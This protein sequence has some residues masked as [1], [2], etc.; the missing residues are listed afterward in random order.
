MIKVYFLIRRDYLKKKDLDYK[1]YK[2]IF[3]RE[4]NSGK[5]IITQDTKEELII[6]DNE[7][8]KQCYSPKDKARSQ[9]PIYWF[10]SDQGNLISVYK[11]K[12]YWL[13]KD[14]DNGRY[15]YH[16]NIYT[17]EETSV[18]KNIEAHNLVRIVFGGLSYGI[19]EDMLQEQGI[20]AFGIK[21]SEE[22]KLNGHHIAD[23]SDNSPGN[24]ELVSTNA[25]KIIDKVPKKNKPEAIAKFLSEF[26]DMAAV[27][28]P[29]KFSILLTGQKIDKDTLEIIED[30]G[31]RALYE[32]D[33]I[34][35]SKE[36][37]EQLISIQNDVKNRWLIDRIV[38]TLTSTYGIEYFLEPKYLCTQNHSFFKCEKIADELVITQVNDIRELVDKH[39]I[40]CYL[41]Q[42][43]KAECMIESQEEKD[44][45]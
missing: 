8:W 44:N 15:S 25:H 26:G 32:T 36:A 34:M 17:D 21:N 11:N 7:K 16:F 2:K 33:K 24:V 20:F 42:D 31:S 39:F 19:A 5:K 45:V 27:E 6:D 38:N 1:D 40:M 37:V 29:D 3:D 4:M 14:E 13:K 43:N 28:V 22:V 23:K 9:L 35:L 18:K 41:N 10:V 12:A 30:D